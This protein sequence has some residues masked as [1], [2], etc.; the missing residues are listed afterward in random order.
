MKNIKIAVG[1]LMLGF[2]SCDDSI[3][4][5][6]YNNIVT[7]QFYTNAEE[8][9]IGLN[10]CY[11]GMR[12]PL[13]DEWA[14]TEIRSDNAYMNIAATSNENNLNLKDLDIFSPPPNMDHIYDYWYN[15]YRNI[16]NVN[17]LLESLKV[18]YVVGNEDLVFE[19]NF[20]IPIND[21]FRKQISAEASFIRAHH[22]F[23]LVRLY[24]DTFL[25]HEVVSP[26]D[27]PNIN[28][29]PVADVY[30][31]IIADLKNAAAYANSST[32]ASL[33]ATDRGKIT[34]WAAKTL[35]AKVYLTLNRK[36]DAIPLLN[37]V[38]NMSGH[39]LVTSSYANIFSITNEM[40]SE[41]IF[42]IRF[43]GGGIGQGSRLANLFAPA[44]LYSIPGNGSGFNAITIEYSDSFMTGDTRKSMNAITQSNGRIYS[45]KHVPVVSLPN[46][47]EADWPVLRFSDVLL[48]L[49]EAEGN[50]PA[51]IGNINLVHQRAGLAAYNTSATYTPAQFEKILADE[52]R[53]EFGHENQRFFD[54]LRFNSTLTTI[55]A[56][57]VMDNHFDLMASVY[58]SYSTNTGVP[59]LSVIKSNSNP[60]R[61]LL[62]IPQQEIDTNTTITIPQNPSY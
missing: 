33:A 1:L 2:I 15:S 29:S 50:T 60:Q 52:R 51:S 20:D 47:S 10:G 49:A 36:S 48:M 23:N 9:N 3:D 30:K 56:E 54:L 17:F 25:I 21:Q 59:D 27:S 18:N 35:L 40:N 43:K 11:A 44:V 22:Y 61:Y 53:W 58:A 19:T 16:R 45:S 5:E 41:I 14:L 4:L 12:A 7:E 42:A 46:E 24:G 62:P 31:L 6:N 37:E 13:L 26:K 8:I 39:A 32:Y 55:N 57:A 34:S 38:K 28:R